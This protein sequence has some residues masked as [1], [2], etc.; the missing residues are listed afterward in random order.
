[1]IF[2]WF[3]ETYDH[4]SSTGHMDVIIWT[5]KGG[6]ALAAEHSCGCHYCVSA[7]NCVRS[8]SR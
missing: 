5:G 8:Q 2:R 6:Q 3:H 1:V 4:L 7:L